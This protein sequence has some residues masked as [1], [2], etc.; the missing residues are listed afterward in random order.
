MN[1]RGFFI[2][3]EP[4]FLEINFHMQTDDDD[5]MPVTPGRS[6][7]GV[8]SFKMKKSMLRADGPKKS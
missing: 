3:K 1:E 6:M 4:G 5:L 8:E 2:S 7:P